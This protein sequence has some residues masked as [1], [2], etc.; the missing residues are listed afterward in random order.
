MGQAYR[1]PGF[2]G[3]V[4]LKDIN[5]SGRVDF[6]VIHVAQDGA[7]RVADSS[8]MHACHHKD[9][10]LLRVADTNSDDVIINSNAGAIPTPHW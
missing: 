5:G 1:A 6:I 9:R 4:E 8:C 7:F 10:V 2:A 3:G